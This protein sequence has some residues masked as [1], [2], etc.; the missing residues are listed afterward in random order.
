MLVGTEAE[1]TDGLTGV[2]GATEEE[3]VGTSR[4]TAGELVEGDGLTT[5]LHNAG[6]GTLGEAEG[7]NG[8]LLRGGLETVVV[9]DSA[10]DNNGLAGGTR[11]LESTVDAGNRDRRAVGLREEEL[12]EDHLVEFGVGATSKEAVKL[13]EQAQV[14]VLRSRLLTLA[15]TSVGLAEV[16]NS[17]WYLVCEKIELG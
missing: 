12:S 9:G 7:G 3:S 14:R 6:T 17:H 15:A 16:V 4:G 1:V 10:N 8:D 11:A 2:A 13:H 5:S